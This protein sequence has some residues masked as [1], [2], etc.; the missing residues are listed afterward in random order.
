MKDEN[1]VASCVLLALNSSFLFVA[2]ELQ[3]SNIIRMADA[4]GANNA[5]SSA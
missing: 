2:N 4:Q 3:M 5:M 1:K